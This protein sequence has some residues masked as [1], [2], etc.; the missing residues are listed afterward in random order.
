[1]D[2]KAPH[3]APPVAPRR[4]RRIEQLGRVRVDDYAWM[5]DENWRQVLHDPSALAPEIRAH[6]QAENAYTAAMLAST[7]ALQTALFEEMK[8]RIKP[9]D[10]T[11]PAPDGPF[12]YYERY[13]PGAQHPVHARR[14]R[15]SAEGEAADEQVLIDADALAR[16]KAYFDLG[17]SEHSPD[18]SLYAWAADEQGSEVYRVFVKDLASGLVMPDPVADS[19]GDF[20]WSADS[21][22]LYWIWR[23]A[24]G[25]PAK[26]FR[27]RSRRGA[28]DDVLVYEE[29][30]DGFFLSLH[31]TRCEGW[32]VISAGNHETSEVRLIPPDDPTGEPRVVEPR[33]PG[34]LYSLDRWGGRWVIRT[35]ADEAVDFKLM[36]AEGP[37]LSKAAWRELVAHQPGRLINGVAAFSDHLVRAERS[38]AE[39]RLVVT[40]RE[41][42]AE[43]AVS[44]EEEAYA[45]SM[46]P[47]LEYDT[48]LLR[49]VY[50][51]P[52]TPRQWFDYDMATR[53]RILLKTQ[54]IPSGHDPSRYLARR[55]WARA[56]DGEEIPITLLMR[57]DA[58]QDG[59]GPLL[60]YGYG[61]YGLAMEA[62]FSIV[63]LSLVDRGWIWAVAHV[64]GGSEKG[65]GWFLDGRL[66]SKTNT[67][68]DFIACAEHLVE[69]GYTRKGRIVAQGG[70]AGGML[71]GA[72]ANLRPDLFAGIVA[73]VPFV[74]VL[75]TISD[76]DLPLT[77]AEWPEWGDPIRDPKAYDYIASYSPYDNV[78]PR[79][80]PAILATGGLSDPRVTYWEPAKWAAKLRG[81]TTSGRPVLLK[82]NMDAGHA[83]ASG[84]FDHLKDPALA[85]AFAIWIMSGE[86][87][88][89]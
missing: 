21:R 1:M 34:V 37:D 45:L 16:G 28:A 46:E 51:S 48:G 66:F 81:A 36:T 30:D 76:E 44:F 74:D 29:P 68:T 54:E 50:Q 58:P 52:T 32:I 69:A 43:H 61:S 10:A 3:P 60:L 11:V 27:R 14:A 64:R 23:D 56:A 20:T 7:E 6:L 24:E 63:R 59:S 84:R 77:P 13:A 5:K 79:A 67:F 89:A 42:L 39:D 12:Q 17:H 88:P 53:T 73:E 2:T 25:R 65:R 55:L 83:G 33:K 38:N 70:S 4:P 80:Y 49:F 62:I 57:R 35:N 71:M 75:N 41:T 86:G 82:I 87:E 47:G 26:V 31:R 8:A 19:T 15:S 85:Y 72:A 9:D 78:A 40:E 18:H 22:W